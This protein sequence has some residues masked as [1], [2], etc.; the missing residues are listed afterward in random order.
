M[1]VPVGRSFPLALC[2]L[3]LLRYGLCESLQVDPL[4]DKQKS[5]ITT[6]DEAVED[7]HNSLLTSGSIHNQS[8]IRGGETD[9]AEMLRTGT[10]M[11][12]TITARVAQQKHT[13]SQWTQQWRSIILSS[14]GKTLYPYCLYI[15]SLDLT[16]LEDLFDDNIFRSS[17]QNDFFAGDMAIFLRSHDTPVKRPNRTTRRKY[18]KLEIPPILELVG[19][20]ISK[21]VSD[22]AF[23]VGGVAAL[24]E[25]SGKIPENVLST[26]VSRLSRLQSITLWDGAILNKAAADAIRTN[27]PD[28]QMLNMWSCLGGRADAELA[29]FFVGLRTNSLR[30]LQVNSR[31]DIAAE[32]YLALNNHGQSL[33]ELTLGDISPPGIKA[34]SL[35]S[36]CVSLE[37][38]T[39]RDA[40]GTISLEATENDTFLEVVAWMK[41]CTELK[42]IR[43][44]RFVDGPSLL[45]SLC[46]EHR[47]RLKSLSLNHYRLASNQD[48]HRALAHQPGLESLELRADVE[49]SFAEDIDALVSSICTLKELNDLNLLEVSDNFKTS[50]VQR[51]AASLPKVCRSPSRN[52]NCHKS[53]MRY[54]SMDPL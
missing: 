54:P 24:E 10:V 44:E 30:A 46:L 27:C 51:L 7:S 19:E 36:G 32:S 45:T 14:L 28:F 1:D 15:R 20:S 35:L 8:S 33:S 42:H 48:L 16:N 40:T 43:L 53:H 37:I 49:E 4:Y 21:Y 31:N 29:E 2:R 12:T 50:E 26:W 18:Q 41:N 22:S 25:L 47:I 38:L 6:T 5:F 3:I 17:M 52:H 13:V 39:L 11:E 34:L 23:Q 9:Q